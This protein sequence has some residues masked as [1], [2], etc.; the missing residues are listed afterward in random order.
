MTDWLV[1]GAGGSLGSVLMRVLSEQRISAEGFVT[2]A[3]PAPEVGKVTR[4]DLSEVR[5]YR[6]RVFALQPRVIVHLAAVSAIKAAYEDPERARAIN[7]DA[8]AQ[9]IT[10]S[11]AIGAHFIYASTDLVFDGEHAPY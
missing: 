4:V 5:T 10:M 11:E 2:L 3:G 1:T 6:D 8:T 7:I 9:L